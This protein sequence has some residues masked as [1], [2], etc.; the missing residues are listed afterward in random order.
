[1]NYI[2]F[3]ETLDLDDIAIVGGKNASLGEM[4][5]KLQP[6]GVDVPLGFATTAD[7]YRLFLDE[8]DLHEPIRALL[9][10]LDIKNSA[11]LQKNAQAIRT[12]IMESTMPLVLQEEIKRAYDQLG[13]TYKSAQLSVAVRSSGTA[14]DLPEASFAGQQESFLNIQGY[15]ALLHAVHRCMASLFTDR[16]ISYRHSRGFDHFKVALSVGIQKMVKSDTAT[17]GIMFTINTENG[18]SDIIMINAAWGLGE[19]IVGGRVNPDEFYLFKPTLKEGKK[20]IIKRT[21]GSK[22]LKMLYTDDAKN[23]TKNVPTSLQEQQRFCLD[24]AEILSLAHRGLAIE[25]HYSKLAGSYRPMDI[26]WAK[27]STDGKLYIVQARPETVQSKTY[28]NKEQHLYETYTLKTDPQ[29]LKVLAMG[30]AVGEKIGAGKVRVITSMKDFGSFKAGEIL[31]ADNTDPDWEPIMKQASAVITN[32]GGRTCHA[33]IVAREIGVPAIVGTGDAT[34]CLKD[35]QEVT[36]S[37]AQGEE[38]YVYEG[39][40]E[41]VVHQVDHSNL[42]KTRTKLFMNVGNPQHAFAFARLPND[43]VGLARMEFI[44]NSEVKAHP[45]ALYYMQEGK[46]VADEAL[47]KEAMQGYPDPK[48]FFMEKIAQGVGTIAAA[49]YPKPVI[50]RTSDFKSNEYM[51]MTGGR[52]FEKE[53]ENP[54]IG[55]RGASRYYSSEYIHAFTWECEALKYVRDAM[56]FTNVKIMIPFVRTPKEG[57]AV[58][59]IMNQAGLIQGH[60]A[61][62][63]Y[64]MCEIPSN[65]LLA[66]AFLDIFDGYSIG[67]NDLT[68]LVLGV[69]RDSMLVSHVFDERNEAVKMMLHMAMVAAKKKKKYIGI[70]GQ[71]PSDYPEITEFL[72]REGIDSISLNPDSLLKMHEV[73]GRIEADMQVHAKA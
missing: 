34:H 9:K 27:D 20:S 32:R 4:I 62:E 24:D 8:N 45:M 5:Q 66:E 58:I 12:R 71:A 30:K 37:C 54:M 55:F 65:V 2:R 22:A 16:A 31:V 49:F 64:A 63:I 46:K 60:N 61:L 59:K 15:E 43:G 38:G 23:P 53:E 39:L 10:D 26:E 3:F 42:Q 50:V 33:A 29:T 35:A 6:L 18:S 28:L 36:V 68:Q 14:E 21:L 69:D 70:C 51:N 56:G 73:V 72:V 47:I 13:Q 7:A 57:A 19:N 44:I 25:A 41:F 48:T 40:C 11:L 52:A 1:M 17:S 67:S